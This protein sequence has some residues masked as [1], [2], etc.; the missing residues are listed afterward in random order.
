FLC[1]SAVIAPPLQ[2]VRIVLPLIAKPQWVSYVFGRDCSRT[3]ARNAASAFLRFSSAFLRVASDCGFGMTR[4]ASRGSDGRGAHPAQAA[5]AQPRKPG[6]GWWALKSS[7]NAFALPGP[8]L[9]TA[10]R[11]GH[12]GKTGGGGG[13]PS[14]K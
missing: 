2:M 11:G 5:H 7:G 4:R 14:P 6:E 10:F 1:C 13:T 3:R 8:I 9:V 12:S